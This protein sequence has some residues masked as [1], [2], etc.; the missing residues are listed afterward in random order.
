MAGYVGGWFGTGK[1]AP[2]RAAYAVVGLSSPMRLCVPTSSYGMARRSGYNV[3]WSA[4]RWSSDGC[5]AMAGNDA[6]VVANIAVI[7]SGVISAYVVV[8]DYAGVG[9]IVNGHSSL[10]I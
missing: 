3:S 2:H 4:V 7:S 5:L 10:R 8:V 6:A 9:V 1:L